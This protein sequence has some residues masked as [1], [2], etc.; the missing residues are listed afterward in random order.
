MWMRSPKDMVR[1]LTEVAEAMREIDP[2]RAAIALATASTAGYLEGDI[3]AAIERGREAERIALAGGDVVSAATASAAVAWNAFMV[4]QWEE[5]DRRLE[6][7]EPLMRLLLEQRS[8]AGI[9]L[10]ELFATTWVCAE[11]WSDAEP[12]IR[13][14]L[15]V[16]RTMGASLSAASTSLLLASLCWRRGRWDEAL[17]LSVPLLEEPEIPPVT[18]SWMR[19]L[20]AQQA[21]ASGRVDETRSLVALALPVA[22]SAD[23]PLIVAMANAA[24]G[25]LE[26]SLG[27]DEAALT[28]FDR[29]ADLTQRMGFAEPEYFTWQGD[30]LD[31]LVRVGREAEA[32]EL[33]RTLSK[34]GDDG[35]RRWVKGVVARTNGQLDGNDASFEDA[36]SCFDGLGMPFEVAR[37]LVLRGR[38]GDLV[39][40]RRLFL[41]LGA[42][43]WAERVR[44]GLSASA[45]PKGSAADHVSGDV[46][47]S[48]G[49]RRSAP[50]AVLDQ[51]TPQERAVALVAMSGRTNRE[52][53]AELHLSAKTIDHYL[54]RAYR[55][56]GVKNRTELAA[57]IAHALDAPTRADRA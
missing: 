45:G 28:H 40:A 15:H 6:P 29:V 36:L 10:A 19:V 18:L 46:A 54:Q 37:T 2:A 41:R 21:A 51:L 32:R 4:G 20:V 1:G 38:R 16:T 34:L 43:A 23:V 39:D 7:L 52:I 48:P 44:V 11:R 12:L 31:A 33:V 9:H 25:H 42:S 27:N 26:L 49:P 55:R 17:A 5:Y 57:T 30:Y 24:L 35:N 8:W 47:S 22:I 3:G 53:A 50:I 13:Q 14:L 56:L